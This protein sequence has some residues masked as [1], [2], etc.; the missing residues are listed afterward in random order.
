MAISA[1]KFLINPT[2]AEAPARKSYPKHLIEKALVFEMLGT[3]M[4]GDERFYKS[5]I[6]FVISQH[7]EATGES[8][9]IV[10][11]SR[12]KNAFGW[13]TGIFVPNDPDLILDLFRQMRIATK[14]SNDPAAW[15]ILYDFNIFEEIKKRTIKPKRKPRLPVSKKETSRPQT[16]DP[17]T[18]PEHLQFMLSSDFKDQAEKFQQRLDCIMMSSDPAWINEYFVNRLSADWP[19]I[20][21]AD[22]AMGG[23]ISRTMSVIAANPRFPNWWRS[24]AIALMRGNPLAAMDTCKSV[25]SSPEV[26]DFT[27]IE[28]VPHTVS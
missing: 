25:I 4:P 18:V 3:V 6:D 16:I 21:R 22:E 14:D 9:Q 26:K 15:K 24:Y 19:E 27:N 1:P 10:L 23:L 20:G 2:E 7:P 13:P 11:W 12:S 28:T 17:A 5:A 8:L